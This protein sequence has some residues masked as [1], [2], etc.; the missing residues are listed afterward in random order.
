VLA[1]CCVRPWVPLPAMDKKRQI[2]AKIRHSSQ[3]VREWPLVKSKCVCLVDTLEYTFRIRVEIILWLNQIVC[4]ENC[5]S[6]RRYK[7]R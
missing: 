3:I 2:T 7:E 6:E 1:Q 4:E 5:S